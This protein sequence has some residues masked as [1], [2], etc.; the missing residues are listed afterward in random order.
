MRARTTWTET[1]PA[2]ESGPYDNVSAISVATQK[3]ATSRH[4]TPNFILESFRQTLIDEVVVELV[5]DRRPANSNPIR[6]DNVLSP[7][8]TFTEISMKLRLDSLDL[9]HTATSLRSG[10]P[11]KSESGMVRVRHWKSHTGY[12]VTTKQ[13]SAVHIRRYSPF[14]TS[15]PQP[16]YGSTVPQC[17]RNCFCNN[18]PHPTKHHGELIYRLLSCS[19]GTIHAHFVRD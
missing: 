14:S 16:I 5:E 15:E 9:P 3:R 4:Q 19:K 7:T 1:N 12:N 11:S 13:E 18:T 2:L 8:V 17:I 6:S 10:T